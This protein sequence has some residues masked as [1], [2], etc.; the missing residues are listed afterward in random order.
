MPDL[1]LHETTEQRL[2]QYVR[3][4]SHAVMLVGP[5]GIGKYSVGVHLASQLIGLDELNLTR[6]PFYRL[7]TPEK[8]S[9]SIEAVRDLQPFVKLKLPSSAHFR[10][11]LIDQAHRL[12]LEAQNALLKLLEEPTNGTLFILTVPVIQSVLPTIRSRVQ[13]VTLRAPAEANLVPY[14]KLKKYDDSKVRQ[15]YLMSGGLPGLMSALLDDDT[16]HPLVVAATK[17]REFLQTDT[18]NRLILADSL[19]KKREDSL[20]L[21][22]MIEQM[23]HV[24]VKQSADRSASNRIKQWEHIMHL[25]YTAGI[26]L[27]NSAQPKLVLT[28]LALNV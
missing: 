17:A 14:F 18:Y 20:S 28:N 26:E 23:A 27:R 13:Y 2:D 22:T 25:S 7:I 15:M 1:V 11:I 6:Y 5:E 16:D 4:P 9:I 24:A 12:T 8:Q 3:H 21:V 10:I 19:S